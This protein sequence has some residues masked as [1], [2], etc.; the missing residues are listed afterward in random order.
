MTLPFDHT[1]DLDLQ[2]LR[3]EFEI[4]LSHEWD[5]WLTRKERD[6]LSIHDNDSDFCSTMLGWVD[7]PDSNQGDF[8]LGVSSTYLVYVRN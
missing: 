1:H 4:A 8:D 2:I 6:E 5:G 3:S 7:E